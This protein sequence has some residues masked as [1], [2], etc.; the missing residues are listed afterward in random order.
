[1][2][3][4]ADL[5]T[6]KGVLDVVLKSETF[7]IK[8]NLL[9]RRTAYGL[10]VSNFDERKIVRHVNHF[11]DPYLGG[12]FTD[13]SGVMSE[14]RHHVWCVYGF[15]D[16]LTLHG[17][18][19]GPMACEGLWEH[20]AWACDHLVSLMEEDGFVVDNLSDRGFSEWAHQTLDQNF[21]TPVALCVGYHLFKGRDDER[22]E[23]YLKAAI[24]GYEWVR[25]KGRNPENQTFGVINAYGPT[26]IV[27]P[28][29]ETWTVTDHSEMLWLETKLY[30]VTGQEKYLTRAKE[31]MDFI[32]SLQI[33]DPADAFHGA[34]GDFFLQPG[35]K[36]R[37]FEIYE[38]APFCLNGVLALIRL[39][40]DDPQQRQ[41]RQ[42]VDL[43]AYKYLKQVCSFNP[44]GIAPASLSE[45]KFVWLRPY[46]RNPGI[47]Q[48][49][50]QC[51]DLAEF[52]DDNAFGDLATNHIQWVIGLHHG[53][54]GTYAA[55]RCYLEAVP[56]SFIRHI[57]SRAALEVGSLSRGLTGHSG[58][59]GLKMGVNWRDGKRYV[60]ITKSTPHGA[61]SI[62]M[63]LTSGAIGNNLVEDHFSPNSAHCA[64]TV[65]CCD[66]LWM[67]AIAK[68]EKNH[69]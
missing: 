1:L 18:Y 5:K 61:P 27:D 43:Y 16:L 57:G 15:A 48:I 65:I 3:I 26:H 12:G 8:H 56:A 42:A 4:E 10:A 23:K 24:L 25:D 28:E 58:P 44:F 31:R 19:L 2:R 67:T 37:I 38:R 45:N 21:Y 14:A 6:E 11:G 50:I 46:G 66:G 41:W 35:L 40:S 54:P 33:T 52:L 17:E 51:I 68:Y 32:M 39:A 62:I 13:C 20:L 59:F 36:E 55:P 49:A 9:I 29:N 64:E 60:G 47:L 7:D 69:R 34:Y 63:G 53:V 22:A 30:E